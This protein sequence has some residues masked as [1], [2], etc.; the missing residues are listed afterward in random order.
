M[1]HLF[2]TTTSEISV[3]TAIPTADRAV[4]DRLQTATF[5]AG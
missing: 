5:G 3:A 1:L 4:P 2:K